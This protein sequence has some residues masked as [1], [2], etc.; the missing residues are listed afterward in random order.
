MRRDSPSEIIC[1]EIS[2]HLKI[3]TK[4]N[5]SPQKRECKKLTQNSQLPV[6]IIIK[7]PGGKKTQSRHRQYLHGRWA[8]ISSGKSCRPNE[9]APDLCIATQS[10]AETPCRATSA[11][12]CQL[13]HWK[14]TA[15]VQACFQNPTN[16]DTW[17]PVEAMQHLQ[18][19]GIMIIS[20]AET[21]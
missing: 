1:S 11:S 18:D 21:G 5:A 13:H 17:T 4:L 9:P 20:A 14:H 8:Q 7:T 10:S 3:K 2:S 16:K 15:T 12:A 19:R 6:I